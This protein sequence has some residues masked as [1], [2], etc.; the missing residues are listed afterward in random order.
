MSVLTLVESSVRTLARLHFCALLSSQLGPPRFPG[1]ATCT[2]PITGYLSVSNR[3]VLCGDQVPAAILFVFLAFSCAAKVF[4]IHASQSSC[5]RGIISISMRAGAKHVHALEA[6]AP[7]E[8]N[9]LENMGWS[10]F[11]SE[12]CDGLKDWS[13]GLAPRFAFQS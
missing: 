2:S 4:C 8:R 12:P 13:C 5:L 7:A 11:P 9:A 6:Y 1:T 3:M 10:D